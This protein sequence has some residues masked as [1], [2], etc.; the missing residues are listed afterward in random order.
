ML[1]KIS[2]SQ[3]RNRIE[4]EQEVLYLDFTYPEYP[5]LPTYGIK[6]DLPAT[7]VEIK[8]VIGAHSRKIVDQ[9]TRDELA[10][11]QLEPIFEFDTKEAIE[12]EHTYLS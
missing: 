6:V 10:R 4:N 11:K 3:I 9:I 5:Q 8:A 12:L 2:P 1:V 7:N